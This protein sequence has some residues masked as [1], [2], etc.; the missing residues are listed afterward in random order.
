[1]SAVRINV[2]GAM[3]DEASRRVVDAESRAECG[4]SFHQR[5]LA[6]KS[7][8]VP[9]LNLTG[10]WMELLRSVRCH[11]VRGLGAFSFLLLIAG[12]SLLAACGGGSTPSLTGVLKETQT[13]AHYIYHYTPG[14]SV[15]PIYQEAFYN[16]DSAQLSVNLE[17]K[18]QYYKFTDANQKQQLTGVGGNAYSDTSTNSVFTIWPTDNHETTHLLTATIGMPT[19]F[20]NEG[21]AVA[22]QTDPLDKIYTPNW[23]GNSPHYWAKQYLQ[24]GQLPALSSLLDESAFEAFDPNMS[25]PI[26]GSFIRYLID[27]YGMA[28]VLKLFPGASYSDSPSTTMSRFQE[29]FGKS[30]TSAE[31][32]WHAFLMQ[33]KGP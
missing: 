26:A 5:H 32:D 15:N 18:I 30:F 33:Y 24:A 8:D 3:E 17:E 21:M 13:S 27:T 19:P 9:A 6:F 12:F 25:Y 7:W 31:Q 10:K 11:K 16:W 20:I 14:D 1:M 4:E 29:V 2:G 28:A 22:N 23:N